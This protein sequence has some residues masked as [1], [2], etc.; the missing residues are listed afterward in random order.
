MASAAQRH[1]EPDA[2]GG[3]P[4]DLLDALREGPFHVA[5]DLA[6]SHRG[7]SL[8][9]V[10]RRMTGHG[11]RVSQATLSYWRRGRRQPEG[12]RSLH[13]VHIIERSLGLPADS[14]A[15]LIGPHRP[16]GRTSV[17]PAGPLGLDAAL[18]ISSDRMNVFEGIDINANMRLSIVSI[19]QCLHM[20]PGGREELVTSRIAVTSKVDGADRWVCFFDAKAGVGCAPAL[21]TTHGCRPGRVRVD[22]DCGL[23]AVELRFDY[24][25]RAGDS[26]VFGY[27]IGYLG[28][29]PCTEMSQYG[30]RT[31]VR[32]LLL[33]VQFRPDAVPVRCY[34][35]NHTRESELPLGASLACHHLLL[36]AQPG[37]Y[38]IRW[39]WE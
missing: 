25:L 26:Y 6:I 10:Q 9:A 8:E 33:Q 32:E 3:L 28:T 21:R 39:E 24:R 27:D 16:R 13:A 15:R 12:E 20:G 31:P 17:R 5:L 2:I 37:V 36:D 1:A 35:Y 30:I 18:D 11:A 4:C 22:P 19:D 38:G 23:L 14:L 29:P 34:Q 7:L